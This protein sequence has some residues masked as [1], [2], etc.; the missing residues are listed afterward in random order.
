MVDYMAT[1]GWDRPITA[2]D[3]K[4]CYA[5]KTAIPKNCLGSILGLLRTMRTIF[6]ESQN[7]RRQIVFWSSPQRFGLQ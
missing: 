7:L 2:L 1:L 5:D 4:D 3:V 6:A